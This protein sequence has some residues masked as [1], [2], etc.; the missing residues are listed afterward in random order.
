M[1]KEIGKSVIIILL[2][3]LTGY[4]LLSFSYLI[5]VEAIADKANGTNPVFA[6]EGTY[7]TER[8]SGRVLDN[9]TDAL[10]L[11]TAEYPGDE[12]IFDKAINA[13]RLRDTSAPDLYFS[14]I[15]SHNADSNSAE[16]EIKKDAYP[17]YWH[18]YQIFLRP[19]SLLMNF[20]RI[21]VL[22]T[23]LQFSL[24]IVIL[25][26]MKRRAEE[27]AFPFAIMLLFMAPTAVG[28]SLQYS[29][30]YYVMLIVTLLVL[31]NPGNLLNDGNMIY[32]FL[33]SGAATVYLD[34]LTAP[35]IS[36]TAPLCVYCVLRKDE[37]SGRELL[38]MVVKCSFF[39][40]AGYAGMWTGKWILAVIGNGPDFFN[41]LLESIKFRASSTSTTQVTRAGTLLLNIE[42]LLLNKFVALFALLYALIMT[43]AGFLG[44]KKP[45][46]QTLFSA[47]VIFII[48]VIPAAW[49]IILSNHSNIHA[50]FTYRTLCPAVFCML[51][52]LGLNDSLLS[53]TCKRQ[54][55][56]V[57]R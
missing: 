31:W 20:D 35:T 18:G 39:W 51:T 23:A 8:Y 33:L 50:F 48:A 38:K 41:E 22:N 53:P 27:C 7:H 37:L 3:I 13:Y 26:L 24:V 6:A 19:L 54:S 25:L 16:S 5:P 4:L 45:T 2:C 44:R 12:S 1:A 21:R 47:G 15:N 14:Y 9:Y 57:S 43:A 34:L 40:A 30:V 28:R 10:M 49:I 17:R 11:L 42:Y 36:L 55:L 32:L 52:A 56:S 46:K 29:S